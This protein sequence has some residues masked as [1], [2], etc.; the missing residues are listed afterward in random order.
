[1]AAQL[2]QVHYGVDLLLLGDEL[3]VRV[4]ELHLDV[5]QMAPKVEP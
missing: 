3:V 2:L 4:L 1:M 5:G